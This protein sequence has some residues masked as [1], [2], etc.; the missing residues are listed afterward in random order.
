MTSR[1][2]TEVEKDG[3]SLRG[4]EK[5]TISSHPRSPQIDLSG[6]GHFQQPIVQCEYIKVIQHNNRFCSKVIAASNF[7]NKVDV[8]LISNLTRFFIIRTFKQ[9]NCNQ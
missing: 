2:R 3:L 7:Y 1:S 6:F 9:G 8:G 5:E 4:I